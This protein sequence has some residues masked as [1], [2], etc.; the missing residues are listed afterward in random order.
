MADLASTPI[1]AS[2]VVFHGVPSIR[3]TAAKARITVPFSQLRS[4][5]DQLHDH[6][7]LVEEAEREG[8]A[9]W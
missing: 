7:D 9:T 1:V 5:A 3:L 8:L 4:V 6:A 2:P